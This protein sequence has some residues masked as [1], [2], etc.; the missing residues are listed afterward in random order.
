MRLDKKVAFITGHVLLVD[1][2][3]TAGHRF[4][5]GSMFGL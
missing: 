5:L 2:G 4:G 1:G 3:L